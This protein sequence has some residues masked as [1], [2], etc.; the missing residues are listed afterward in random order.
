MHS[1]LNVKIAVDPD[2]TARPKAPSLFFLVRWAA[3]YND[4]SHDS[5]EPLRSLSKLDALRAYLS[6]PGWLSFCCSDAYKA[7]SL[8][9]KSKIPKLVTFAQGD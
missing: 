9:F 4:P 7:F 5:W 3:P 6:S 2:S 1:I 8:K